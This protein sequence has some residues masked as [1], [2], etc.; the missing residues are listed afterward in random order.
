MQ[1]WD[2]TTCDFPKL[3]SYTSCTD[4][5][6]NPNVVAHT[7]LFTGHL[8]ETPPRGSQLCVSDC[9]GSWS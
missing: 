8:H 7:K 9:S 3:F 1:S 2:D 5:T 4:L 6:C